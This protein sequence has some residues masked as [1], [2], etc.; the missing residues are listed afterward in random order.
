MIA[1]IGQ[2]FWVATPIQLA[3]A[4]A[5]LGHD[6]IPLTP[7]ILVATQKG[8]DEEIEQVPPVRPGGAVSVHPENLAAVIEGMVAVMH[9]PSGTARAAALDSPYLIAGKTG[10]A[11]RVSRRGDEAIPLDDLPY[12]L[13]HRALFVALA[14]AEAPTIALAIVVESGGSGS[15]SAAPIAR[16]ILDAWLLRG[17]GR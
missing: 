10:T 13:R 14:P 4:T 11:Q 1:C 3:H 15:R 8:F 17:E 6:G 5:A 12:H 7:R 16:R 2:G 9:S